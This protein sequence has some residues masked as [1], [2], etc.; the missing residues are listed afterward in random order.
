M[1]NEVKQTVNLYHI[2][3]LKI[4]QNECKNNRKIGFAQNFVSE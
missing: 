3:N 2:N 4:K 1:N